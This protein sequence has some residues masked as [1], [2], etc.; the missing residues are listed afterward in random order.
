MIVSVEL[1]TLGEGTWILVTSSI[2]LS[3]VVIFLRTRENSVL[4][5]LLVPWTMIHIWLQIL[6]I[7]MED[8]PIV[9]IMR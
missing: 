7:T 3:N 1:P 4:I 9:K 2:P 8:S 6:W 5:T